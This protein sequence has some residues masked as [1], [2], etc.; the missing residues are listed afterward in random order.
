MESPNSNF[1]DGVH[2]IERWSTLSP[3]LQ[4]GQLRKW[5]SAAAVATAAKANHQ[6]RSDSL[7]VDGPSISDLS[8][9]STDS[10]LSEVLA[11]RTAPRI[12]RGFAAAATPEVAFAAKARQQQLLSALR[13]S[14]QSE[15]ALQGRRIASSI[16]EVRDAVVTLAPPGE[17]PA[18]AGAQPLADRAAR[19]P[20]PP[21]SQEGQLKGSRGDAA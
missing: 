16:Q 10:A 12:V 4:V 1:G 13:K 8:G 18:G 21:A 7:D 20:L 9:A 15:T 19:P 2:P 6:S 5:K 17:A 14:T 11:N 3:V